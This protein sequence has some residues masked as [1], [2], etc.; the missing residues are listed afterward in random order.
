PEE[1][2]AESGKVPDLDELR[3]RLIDERLEKYSQKLEDKLSDESE[4]TKAKKLL[5]Q[6]I[7]FVV[8]E[9]IAKKK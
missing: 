3:D 1:R 5:K 4:L 6:R 2:T 9:A 8:D 7:E